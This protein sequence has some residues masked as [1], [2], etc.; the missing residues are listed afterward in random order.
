[1]ESQVDQKESDFYL[2]H[3]ERGLDLPRSWIGYNP[4]N[5][6]CMGTKDLQ[7]S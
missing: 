5:N 4:W 1:M 2:K 7:S 3:N 6:N